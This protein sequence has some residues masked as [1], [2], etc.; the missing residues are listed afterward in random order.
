MARAYRCDRCYEY[1]PEEPVLDV[2]II[3]RMDATS[4]GVTAFELCP[5]CL[6]DIHVFLEAYVLP[7]YNEPGVDGDA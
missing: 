1:H 3:D 4:K 7:D 2:K 5:N 6:A